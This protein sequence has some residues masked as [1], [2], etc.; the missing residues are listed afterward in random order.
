MNLRSAVR[1]PEKLHEHLLVCGRLLVLAHGNLVLDCLVHGDKILGEFGIL[2]HRDC[3]QAAARAKLGLH[4][5]ANTEWESLALAAI[6]R[7]GMPQLG[8]FE[9]LTLVEQSAG[10]IEVDGGKHERCRR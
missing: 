2:I 7:G 4:V 8:S 1:E 5:R 9:L 10:A 3:D 6:R